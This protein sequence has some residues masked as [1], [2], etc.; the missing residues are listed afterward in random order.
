MPD[1]RT[2]GICER[3]VD[4][5]GQIIVRCGDGKDR[6]MDC[7][8]R[9]HDATRR[10]RVGISIVGGWPVF[11]VSDLD[12]PNPDGEEVQRICTAFQV[13]LDLIDGRGA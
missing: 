6:I 13:A 7:P 9:D 4:N 12:N 10:R 8:S 5:R 11:R 1:T 3:P 2:C